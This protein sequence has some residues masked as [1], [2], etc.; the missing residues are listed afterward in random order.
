MYFISCILFHLSPLSGNSQESLRLHAAGTLRQLSGNSQLFSTL[1]RAWAQPSP[2][3]RSVVRGCLP[4]RDFPNG[5]RG[6]PTDA[7]FPNSVFPFEGAAHPQNS[8]IARTVE[9]AVTSEISQ[10]LEAFDR[11]PGSVRL[12]RGR[13]EFRQGNHSWKGVYGSYGAHR[14]C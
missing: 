12:A 4:E 13:K 14:A 2:S 5:L 6:C 1:L 9:G 10:T 3:Q 11:I 7:E 8:Q